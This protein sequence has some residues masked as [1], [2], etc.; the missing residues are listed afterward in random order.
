MAVIVDD[1]DLLFILTPR[2]GSTAIG[3]KVMIEKWGGRWIPEDDILDKSGRVL[4]PRKHTTLK[5]LL[6]HGLISHGRRAELTAFTTVRNPYESMVSLYLKQRNDYQPLLE[7]PESWVNK[8]P[9]YREMMLIASEK[10]F[11]E[12]LRERYRRGSFPRRAY[13]RVR[14]LVRSPE[15]NMIHGV[16]YVLRFEHLQSEFDRMLNGLGIPPTTIPYYNIT[17]SKDDNWREYYDRNSA[18]LVKH[19]HRQIIKRYGYSFD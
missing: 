2:T 17:R 8:R 3:Q 1:L 7:D 15:L 14:R 18:R 4:I 16:D 11:P 10:V 19:V 5:A 9:G 12:W 6:D 13:R